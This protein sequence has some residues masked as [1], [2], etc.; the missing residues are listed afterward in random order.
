MPPR[1]P[2]KPPREHVDGWPDEAGVHPN[3][4]PE[5]YLILDM[6]KRL[7]KALDDK[8]VSITALARSAGMTRQTIYH[9][10]DGKVWP[11]LSTIASLERALRRKIWGSAH[12]HSPNPVEPP[13][14]DEPP[15]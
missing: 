10:L 8:D 2:R 15:A 9:L 14:T 13:E 1:N 5:V 6:A 3:A 4:P 11:Q 12:K 7:R